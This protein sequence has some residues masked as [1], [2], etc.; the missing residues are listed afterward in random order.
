MCG[1]KPQLCNTSSWLAQPQDG[2]G[3]D[4]EPNGNE[5]G[6]GGKIGRRVG[7]R[8]SPPSVSRLPWTVV[9]NLGHTKKS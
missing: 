6:G 1:T 7:L 5:Y 4:K 8:T 3:V 2:L 9:F